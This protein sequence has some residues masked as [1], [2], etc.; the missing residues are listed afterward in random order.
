M[1]IA[2]HLLERII[3]MSTDEGDIVLDPFLGTG[4]TA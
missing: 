1:S 4:T 2:D 3:L